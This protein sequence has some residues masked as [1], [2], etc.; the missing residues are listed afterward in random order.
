M[1][2]TKIEPVLEK[3]GDY[4]QHRKDIKPLSCYK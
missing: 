4:Y 2:S 1:G 3:T